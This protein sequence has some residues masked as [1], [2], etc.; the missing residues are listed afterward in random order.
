[1]Q[2]ETKKIDE[3]TPAPYNPRKISNKELERL[4]RS[5]SEFGYVEPVIW[6][7]ATGYVVGGHQRLK[8][9][10]E[11]GIEEVECVVIDI[12]EDKEKALNIALN[13]ISGDWDTDKVFE[14]LDELDNN[15]FDITLT[16]F[17]FAD[18]DDFRF[19]SDTDDRYYGDAREQTYDLYRLNEFDE[20]R[21]EGFYQ[22][23]M[24]KACHYIPD[25]L[26]GFNYARSYKGDKKGVGIHFFID[27]YQ[28]ERIWSNPFKQIERLKT[29]SCTLTPQFS[30]YMDM[31]MA[32]K[33]W[34]IYRSRM[35]GQIMQDAGLE[36]IPS[37]VWA[38][39][40]TFDFSF[41]GLEQGG[42]VAV[43]TV[44]VARDKEAQKIWRA[45]VEYMLEKIKPECVLLYGYN[46][47]LDFDWGKT[48]VV[49]YKAK[50][51]NNS[52]D[53]VTWRADK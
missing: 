37:L 32:M 4:K 16:G 19:D 25:G 18:L 6:N 33:I 53:S 51:F 34:N 23:P 15:K 3:L 7:K 44:G 11:L 8:A 31:P 22:I 2:I 5:L 46:P 1:M 40:A 49:F 47:Y 50:Q 27:D 12:P 24:M 29:F 41:S 30:T 28:F 17:E 43:E 38:E 42:V 39:E 52:G 9:M 21:V 13:K 45:G 36:V 14:I 10:K 35:I 20:T 48:K 26:I